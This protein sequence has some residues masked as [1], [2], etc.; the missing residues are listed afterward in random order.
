MEIVYFLVIGAV[1]GWLAGQLMKGR[2]FGL[3]GN[4][5]IGVIGSIVGGTLFRSMGLYPDGGLLSALITALVGAV[6]LLVIA[7][8]FKKA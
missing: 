6:V 3:V 7:G 2:G 1:A 4:M 5:V 8:V